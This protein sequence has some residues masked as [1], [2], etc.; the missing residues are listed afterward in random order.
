[1][2]MNDDT[3]PRDQARPIGE[4]TGR[5]SGLR[6]PWEPGKSPNPGGRPKTRSL[7][8]AYRAKL[9]E[10]FP[11]DPAGRTYA[12]VIAAKMAEQAA[13]GDLSAARE[14]ADRAEG[15]AAQTMS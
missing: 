7:S 12:E 4:N 1:M 14:L 9:E 11:D 3:K 2:P 6:P 13:S 5:T 15:K 8:K 10:P